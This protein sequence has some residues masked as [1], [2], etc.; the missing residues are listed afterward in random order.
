MAKRNKHSEAVGIDTIHP[1][2]I[3]I[4]ADI[5]GEPLTL[6]VNCCLSQ[7]IFSDDAKAASV[8]PFGKGKHNKYDVLNYR[9]V[10]ILNI[11][12]KIYKNILENQLAS[13]LDR[14]SLV[15]W[16]SAYKKGYTIKQA[17]IHLLEE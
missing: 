5:I 13:Y 12:S 14:F 17:L 6:T 4:S 9:P 1:K 16:L 8:V 2:L 3:K 7:G 15:L 10:S 11:F